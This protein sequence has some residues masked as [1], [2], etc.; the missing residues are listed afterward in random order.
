MLRDLSKTAKVSRKEANDVCKRQKET[1][2]NAIC[3]SI[4]SIA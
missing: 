2:I 3:G 4:Q 1:G